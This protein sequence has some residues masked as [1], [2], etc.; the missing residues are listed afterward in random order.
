MVTFSLDDNQL[1][2]ICVLA[3]PLPRPLRSELLRMTAAELGGKEPELAPYL[4]QPGSLSPR[5]KPRFDAMKPAK[6][7]AA[8][9]PRARTVE[10]PP[11]N[12]ARPWREF[13]PAKGAQDRPGPGRC[14]LRWCARRAPR[15]P[16]TSRPDVR[17]PG[18]LTAAV[19]IP[20]AGS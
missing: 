7:A 10:P 17:D 20:G 19:G 3:E 6:V 8:K 5:G 14:R 9:S 4:K 18:A 12:R 11:P 2:Q 13:R 15:L 16:P 1:R